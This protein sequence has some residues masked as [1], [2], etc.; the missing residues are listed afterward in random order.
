[1]YKMNEKPKEGKFLGKCRIYDPAF[2][3]N[4]QNPTE[5]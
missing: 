4:M 1:M 2:S 5:K 3:D